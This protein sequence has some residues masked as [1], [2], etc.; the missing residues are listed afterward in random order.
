MGFFK[1]P[2]TVV[3][4]IKSFIQ[5]NDKRNSIL[6]TCCGYGEALSILA[7]NTNAE[8]FGIEL[9]GHRAEGARSVLDHVLKSDFLNTRISNSCFNLLFLNPPYDD[10]ATADGNTRKE[11]I[12]LVN[13]VKYLQPGGLLVYIIPQRRLDESIAKILSYRFENIRVF[14]FHGKEYDAFRQIIIMGTRKRRNSLDDSVCNFL[15][16]V[17]LRKLPEIPV[18]QAK[19]YF[20]PHGKDVGLFKSTEID[21]KELEQEVRLSPL[22]NLYLDRISIQEHRITSPPL[23][24]HKGHIALLLASGKLDGV[25]G[26]GT[27]RHLVR[28]AVEKV[29]T[30]TEEAAD[31]STI[32]RE[33]ERFR[34]SIKIL[35]LSGEIRV[36]TQT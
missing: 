12:F 13:G 5:F 25:V 14:R 19:Y 27:D 30:K 8:T 28:G 7:E 29:A 32:I 23:P 31:D 1:T 3:E 16:A 9:D 20:L 4:R 36:L 33:K 26:E 24:L 15:K 22:W 35:T 34:V 21:V 6:D 10:E 18:S 17:P 11:K 2:V